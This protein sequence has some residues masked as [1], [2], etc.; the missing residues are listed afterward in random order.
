MKNLQKSTISRLPRREGFGAEASDAFHL[1]E[2]LFGGVSS[3]AEVLP[4]LSRRSFCSIF[5]AVPWV[6]LFG[7][8]MGVFPWVGWLM[9]I[10]LVVWL[11]FFIFPY[12]GNNHPN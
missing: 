8:F 9:M 12:M 6:V 1:A 2:A 5:L 11:P 4:R 3:G 10:W 7:G